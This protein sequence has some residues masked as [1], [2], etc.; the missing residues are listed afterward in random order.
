MVN[1][2]AS[3]ASSSVSLGPPL[4]LNFTNYELR[5]NLHVTQS[6][7]QGNIDEKCVPLLLLYAT[8]Y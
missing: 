5:V 3:T 4:A 1:I 6:R 8:V 2:I 7:F